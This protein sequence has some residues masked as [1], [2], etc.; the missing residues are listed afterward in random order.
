[1]LMFKLHGSIVSILRICC[2]VLILLVM[3]INALSN[4]LLVQFYTN[5]LFSPSAHM[6]ESLFLWCDPQ[7]GLLVSFGELLLEKKR[8]FWSWSSFILSI[9][10]FDII[11]C[12]CVFVCVLV[13]RLGSYFFSSIVINY[14]ALTD[15]HC[16]FAIHHFHKFLVL[17]MR[18]L[19][20][21]ATWLS[22]TKLLYLS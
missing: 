3:G 8:G 5:I 13:Y 21:W 1:M 15:G 7:S 17:L 18:I 14:P 2:N 9:Y 16:H 20:L 11:I 22:L 4:I 6:G 10:V 12:V 19:F